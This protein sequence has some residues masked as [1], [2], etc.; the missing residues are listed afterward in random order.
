MKLGVGRIIAFLGALIGFGRGR[1]AR[2]IKRPVFEVADWLQ[3]KRKRGH[4]TTARCRL[5]R[6]AR[7][8]VKREMEKRSRR[9]NWGL[10]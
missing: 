2:G 8:R 9:V 3:R 4:K 10:L 1:E 7:R 6:T 5:N